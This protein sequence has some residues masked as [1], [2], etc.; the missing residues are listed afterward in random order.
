MRR[1]AACCRPAERATTVSGCERGVFAR[2]LKNFNTLEGKKE[3]KRAFARGACETRPGAF[4]PGTALR[5]S[6][7]KIGDDAYCPYCLENVQTVGSELSG[8]SQTPPGNCYECASS[9][10]DCGPGASWE[11]QRDAGGVA[12]LVL[13]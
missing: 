5:A 7:L 12:E 10:R 13:D 6:R 8:F 1:F 11:R 9:R 2:A 4:D 3:K